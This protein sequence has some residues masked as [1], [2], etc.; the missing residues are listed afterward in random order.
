[1][2]LNLNLE[3]EAKILIHIDKFQNKIANTFCVG[4]EI[5]RL[6]S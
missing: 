5:F 4:R 1:M 6:L 3:K 2:S